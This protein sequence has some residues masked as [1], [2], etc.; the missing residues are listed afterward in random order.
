M[1]GDIVYRVY[2][3][4][5]G[6]AQDNYFGS[7]RAP[8]EAEAK[9]AQLLSRE[10]NGRNWAEQCHNRGFVIREAVVDTDFEIPT[11]PTPRDRYFVQRAPKANRPGT[12]D[13][14][15]ITVYRRATD[16]GEPERLCEY[17]RNYGLLQTFEPFRQ[18]NRDF[19]LIAPDYTA[20]SVLD[21]AT[22]QVIAA[23]PPAGFGFCPVGFY[24]PDW[25]DVNDGSVIPGGEYWSADKEWPTGEF[26]FVWGCI[27]GDD[28]SW[29]VQF[30]DLREIQAG[31]IRRDE[32]FGYVELATNSSWSPCFTAD[33]PTQKPH[34][35]PFIN[36]AQWGGETKVTFAVEME[37]ELT[38]GKPK[39]WER[40]RV[41]DLE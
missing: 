21:L 9:I 35:P 2:G 16:G 6:R 14:T 39:E 7:F 23:E 1:R 18:G 3:V 37:F 28:S 26:G 17:V 19:A 25:W 4:H 33:A 34:T 10:L 38:S 15:V 29:K 36:L 12:W 40:L 22:G 8:T 32:R 11:Q 24:V 5:E 41:D 13:S 31:V 20:T 27:W 30:L